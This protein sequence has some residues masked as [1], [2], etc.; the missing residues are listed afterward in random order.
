[1]APY[2]RIWVN[3]SLGWTWRMSMRWASIL[4][5]GA[6][7]K[8]LT[9]ER[10]RGRWAAQ[11]SLGKCGFSALSRQSPKL[12]CMRRRGRRAKIYHRYRSYGGGL[13]VQPKMPQKPLQNANCK[14]AIINL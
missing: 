5:R 14:I 2:G 9:R 8:N 12:C 4:V 3:W 10:H 11:Y 1:M 13:Q 7:R 6:E